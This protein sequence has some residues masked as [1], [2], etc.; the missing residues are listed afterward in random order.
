MFLAR[1]SV[2]DVDLLLSIVINNLLQYMLLV[3]LQGK[4][5]YEYNHYYAIA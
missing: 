2:T 3:Q 5:H 1:R 4:N